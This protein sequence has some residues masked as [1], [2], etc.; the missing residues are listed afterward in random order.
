MCWV[1]K[2]RRLVY[3]R[4][5][6]GGE[7]LECFT[8]PLRAKCLGQGESFA[9]WAC[10]GAPMACRGRGAV[11]GSWISWLLRFAGATVPSLP[12]LCPAA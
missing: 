8:S 12:P 2:G 7:Q 6:Y 9:P 11:W 1:G 5:V 3:V 4:L 10:L